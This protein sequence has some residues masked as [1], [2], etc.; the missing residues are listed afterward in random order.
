MPEPHPPFRP[1]CVKGGAQ[2]RDLLG[3]SDELVAT[4]DGSGDDV[5]TAR[6]LESPQR[7]Q[8]PGGKIR[9]RLPEC[10]LPGDDADGVAKGSV[11]SV[12]LSELVPDDDVTDTQTGGYGT[13]DT[14]ED[15][16]RS[17]GLNHG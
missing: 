8:Y 13:S 14:G 6:P 4:D 1:H 7:P 16:A 3:L 17:A 12:V 10:W 15:D 11:V 2:P 5:V 9:I